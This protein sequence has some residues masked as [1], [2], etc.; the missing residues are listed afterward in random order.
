MPQVEQEHPGAHGQQQPDGGRQLAGLHD[1][2]GQ[3][4]VGDQFALGN[5]DHAG[6]RKD[7]HQ[8]DGQQRVD[9]ARGDAVLR[10][11]QGD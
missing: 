5:E 3:R 1:G 7:Q 4:A 6:D 8:A 10:Q 9:G 11:D 2:D